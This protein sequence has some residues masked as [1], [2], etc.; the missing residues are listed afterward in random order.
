MRLFLADLHGGLAITRAALVAVTVFVIFGTGVELAVEALSS[1]I[2]SD[3]LGGLPFGEIWLNF[4][5]VS[6][7]MPLLTTFLLVLFMIEIAA[8]GGD[9]V[10]GKATRM[11][12]VFRGRV[13]WAL[14]VACVFSLLIVLLLTWLISAFQG[15]I[16][17]SLLG[18]AVR[19]GGGKGEMAGRLST[20]QTVGAINQLLA[21]IAVAFGVSR[22]ALIPLIVRHRDVSFGEAWT[23]QTHG[24]DNYYG[25]VRNRFFRVFLALLVLDSLFAQA[26][27]Q[28]TSSD[29]IRTLFVYPAGILLVTVVP[30][31]IL[32]H[33]VRSQPAPF[34]DTDEVSSIDAENP[35]EGRPE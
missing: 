30:T 5:V 23:I 25:S 31:G 2:L 10:A 6:W 9:R 33:M 27:S 4:V 35:G 15:V 14:F 21:L 11:H 34:R 20:I 22:Y 18:D 28:V 29:L 1:G 19:Q 32:T 13:A 24:F 16:A 17:T 8:V 3:G 26:V 7:V 12:L